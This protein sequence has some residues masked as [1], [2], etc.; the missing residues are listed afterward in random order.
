M[1]RR[2][3]KA[4]VYKRQIDPG[5]KVPDQ[6]LHADQGQTPVLIQERFK[7]YVY[8]APESVTITDITEFANTAFPNGCSV[9]IIHQ[10]TIVG[11]INPKRHK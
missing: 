9:K 3:N 1:S 11:G 5:R 6:W 8:H 4:L 10:T 2:V 7:S